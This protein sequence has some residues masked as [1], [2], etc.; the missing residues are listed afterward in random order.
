MVGD[1]C[2]V[3]NIG[4]LLPSGRCDHCGAG[5]DVRKH[6][7]FGGLAGPVSEIRMA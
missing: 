4:Y 5:P 2:Q 7:E 6:C 3:C 1:E